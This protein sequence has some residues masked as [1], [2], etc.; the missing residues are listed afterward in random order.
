LSLTYR[1]TVRDAIRAAM[2]HAS[3]GFNVRLNALATA[4]GI[5]PFTIDWTSAES[6]TFAQSLIDPQ[7]IEICQL[8][9]FPAACLYTEQAN[10]TGFPR[11]VKFSGSMVASLDFWQRQRD[12]IES[13]DT[14]SMS[15][16][17]EDAAMSV[18]NDPTVPWPINSSISVI[19]A[20]QCAIQ[21]DHLVPLADGF[22]QRVSIKIPFEVKCV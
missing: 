9:D 16:A 6:R 22:G 20:R 7:N 21:R 15:D 10:D 5:T 14:E 1:K 11:G 19:F 17:I 3:T 2:A 13:L 4:Y 18:L 8:L 12:G